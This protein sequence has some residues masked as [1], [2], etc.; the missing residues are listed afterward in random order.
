MLPETALPCS[1]STCRADYLEAL[2]RPRARQRRRPAAR[3]SR[4]TCEGDPPRYYN[5]V[6]S[7]GTQPTQVYRKYHL[8]PF[9]DYV[10][11]WALHHLDHEHAADPDVGFLARRAVPDAAGGRRPARGGQHL[12]RGRV[13]RGDHPPVAAR[14]RCSPTS[15]TTPGGATRSPPSSTCRSRRCARWKPGA[16]C[17]ARPIPASPP[18]SIDADASSRRVPQFVV[19]VLDGQA[20]GYTGS[21][22]YVV[23]GN[24]AFLG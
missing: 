24:W 14:P 23:W 16:T 11:H 1:M 19:A 2:A 12:L 3:R 20:Q 17:C 7:F 15:P 21:T 9:G 22:P 8:V 4:S 5:S 18:S 10:P 13:R 6:M